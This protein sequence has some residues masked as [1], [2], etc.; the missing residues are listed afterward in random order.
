MAKNKRKKQEG[1]PKGIYS[2]VNT[3][4]FDR[5]FDMFDSDFKINKWYIGP[6]LQY[7]CGIILRE[8]Q[9]CLKKCD[10]STEMYGRNLNPFVV[11]MWYHLKH[12]YNEKKKYVPVGY[13]YMIHASYQS[14]DDRSYGV[15]TY[16]NTY[17]AAEWYFNHAKAL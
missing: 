3:P 11:S 15:S 2:C 7:S 1:V 4:D 9:A 13:Q 10:N 6:K 8:T 16:G 17:E 14:I 12:K 5:Y